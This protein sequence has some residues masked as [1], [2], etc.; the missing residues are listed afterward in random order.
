MTLTRLL[1]DSEDD[2]FLSQWFSPN[3]LLWYGSKAFY[4]SNNNR[5]TEMSSNSFD[6]GWKR[7]FCTKKNILIQFLGQVSWEIEQDE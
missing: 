4:L 7:P 6:G 1:D 2:L 5:H 3:D